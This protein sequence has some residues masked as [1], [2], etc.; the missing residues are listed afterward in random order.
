MELTNLEGIA[1]K[2][3]DAEMIQDA[4]HIKYILNS[5][6]A[7]T[8]A[9]ANGAI[10]IWK[11]DSEAIRGESMR[12]LKVLDSKIFNSMADCEKWYRKWVKKI[13]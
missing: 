5:G 9:A 3:L 4:G 10:N 11:D 6:K 1:A 8:D 12:N 13:Q 7:A 2:T